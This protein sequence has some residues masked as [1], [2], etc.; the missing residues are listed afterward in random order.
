MENIGRLFGL[1]VKNEIYIENKM[2]RRKNMLKK[3]KI[4]ITITVISLLLAGSGCAK[5]Q[6]NLLNKDDP[7]TLSVWHYYNG[8]QQTMF[9]EMV[10]EFNQTVG[11]DQ[12]VIVE[13]FSQN[14]ISEL[15]NA[16]IASI[17]EEVGAEELPNLFTAYAETAYLA[18]QAGKLTDL[19]RYFT[20]EE[21]EEYISEYIEEGRL[22]S[23]DGLKIFPIAKSTEVMMINKTDW[24][25][26]A[27]ASGA[28]TDDLA[29]WEGLARTAEAYYEYTDAMTPDIENDG[30]AFFGRDSLANYVMIGAKQLEHPFANMEGNGTVSLSCDKETVRRLWDNYYVPYIK[31]YYTANS[32]FRSDDAKT[33][34]IIALICSTTGAV[35][36]PNA[37][38]ID[39]DTSY[40]IEAMVIP[41]PDFEGKEGCIVQQGAG[42]CVT[43]ADEKTEYA[44]A[45]FLKWFTEK[46]RNIRYAVSSGYLPVKKAANDGQYI[47]EVVKEDS[48]SQ[49]MADT[50]YV[51]IDEINTNELYT[52]PPFDNSEKVRDFLG[53]YMAE[54]V[55]VN[56]EAALQRIGEGE[57]RE[58]VIASYTDNAAFE[59][60]YEGFLSGFNTTAGR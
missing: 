22:L 56:R 11:M 58:T 51:A 4:A 7:V 21:Q 3:R 43:C 45:L 24:E 39:D 26:F 8:V 40:P 38:T 13:A 5:S 18:D 20:K 54:T 12:G 34:D 37:V 14:S 29:T 60:W 9:D 53:D 33:G 59:E 19:S 35:Y 1:A 49:I 6:K 52:A 47:D 42:M 27:L 55:A 57:D 25:Q 36:F 2:E 41:V 46:E 10:N 44:C 17:E 30:K 31:G 50:L 15:N 23:E 28:T 16:I 32:R 48:I